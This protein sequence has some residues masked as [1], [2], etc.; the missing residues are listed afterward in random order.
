MNTKPKTGTR[1]LLNSIIFTSAFSLPVLCCAELFL[2]AEAKADRWDDVR[3]AKREVQKEQHDIYESYMDLRKEQRQHDWDG[4]KDA[5]R[6]IRKNQHEYREALE[7]YRREAAEVGYGN[8]HGRP[9]NQSGNWQSG[10]WQSG[11][12][13]YGNWGSNNSS[14]HYVGTGYNGWNYGNSPNYNWNT[15]NY[16]NPGYFN[17]VQNVP[18][19]PHNNY[20]CEDGRKRW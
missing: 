3:D 17:G 14:N 15:G 10:N 7:D 1:R 4:I 9:Y 2:A 16:S 19:R 18:T 5:Q 8:R 20:N 13:Q 12:W 6:N 11:N